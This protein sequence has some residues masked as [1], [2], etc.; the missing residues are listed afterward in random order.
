MANSITP[1]GTSRTILGLFTTDIDTSG[2]ITASSF[3]GIGT[4]IKK[5]NATNITS[6][7]LSTICGGTGNSSYA[8]NGITYYNNNKLVN[9]TNLQWIGNALMINNRDFLSDTSNYVKNTSNNLINTIYGANDV[10]QF[11]NTNNSNYVL[12]T[13]NILVNYINT[14]KT[15]NVSLPARTNRLG[16]VKIGD[17]IYVNKEGTISVMPEIIY[18][19]S[20]TMNNLDSSS[21]IPNTDYKIYK[22]KYN[23]LIGTS[24]DRQNQIANIL[25]TWFQF[26]SDNLTTTNG[27]NSIKNK[28]YDSN[29]NTNLELYGAVAIKP[30]PVSN[31]NKE[32]TPLN[33]TYLEVNGVTGTPTYCKFGA[34]FNLLN[35]LRANNIYKTDW[36]LTISFWFKVNSSNNEIRILDCNNAEF[37][38]TNRIFNIHY[39]DN[40]L[41]FFINVNTPYFTITNINQKIWYHIVWSIEKVEAMFNVRAY[42]DGVERGF[43]NEGNDF[44]FYV[45]FNNF[46]NNSISSLNNTNYTYNFNLSDF[47]IYN[48]ALSI[49]EINELYNANNYTQYIIDF[50]NEET[51]CDIIAYG[52]GGGGSIGSV[53]LSSNYGGGAGKLIYVNDAYIPPGSKTLKVGRGGIGYKNDLNFN[54]IS[55]IGNSTIFENLIADGGGTSSNYFNRNNIYFINQNIGGCGSG[56]YGAKT[57]FNITNDLY[58]LFGGTSNIYNFGH[59]GGRYGGGGIGSVGD[60]LN[61][62]TGLFE[63]SG[64]INSNI[65]VVND[66]NTMRYF[67]FNSNINFKTYFNLLNDDNIGEL[68][69]GNIY[70]GCGGAGNSN[71]DNVIVNG[72]QQLGYNSINSGCGGNFGENG[73]NGAFFLRF[74]TKIDQRILPKYIQETSNYVVVS[75]NNIIN[76]VSTSSNNIINYVKNITSVNGQSLWKISNNNL[77]YNIGNV[78]IG[79]EPTNYKLEVAVGQGSTDAIANRYFNVSGGVITSLII[80]SGGSGYS[81]PPT[82][83]FTGGGGSGGTGN[84]VVSN[85]AITSV[86]ITSGGS[87]YTS[88]PVVSFVG[89]NGATGTAVLTDGVITSVIITAGGSE[90]SN[91]PTISF[92]G[93]DGSGA[94][95]NVVVSNGVITSVNITSGGS[96]YSSPPTVSFVGGSGATGTV[97]LTGGAISSL[98]ITSG[99]S[100]YSNPPTISFTGGGGIGGAGNVVV[101]NGAITSVRITSGGI[102][103]TSP[104]AVSFVGG[105]GATGTAVLTGGVITSIVITAGGNGYSNPPTVS[106]AGGGGSGGTGNVVVSNGVITS[107]NI[108]SGGSG[109][110]SLPTMVFVGGSGATCTAFISNLLTSTVAINDVCTKFNSSIWIAGGGSVIASSDKRIKEDIEDINDDS[111][112]NMIL[113]IEPKTYKYIDKVIKGDCKVY[114]FIAQQIREVIADAVKI[115]TE[116]IPNIFSVAD[117]DYINNILTLPL[118]LPF[119][120]INIR[121]NTMIKCIDMNNN[122]IVVEIVKIININTFEIKRID[123]RY[124]KIFVYGTEVN[125]FHALNKEYINTL[126]VCAVQELHRKIVLQQN[127]INDLTEKINLLINYFDLSKITSLEEEINAMKSRMDTI[128]SCIDLP[129]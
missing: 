48:K 117:Y 37:L 20:P 96:G 39:V 53:N 115:Q 83:S 121:V 13:S 88:P 99:G 101:S 10:V 91:P 25:P 44:L 81:N 18:M 105:N 62:G 107:V 21:P 127:Q 109:Y 40:K 71:I 122:V 102:G 108:T 45:S 33:T 17:G 72:T 26:I 125:D 43:K 22:L 110:T 98:T 128:I 55:T 116:F 27:I 84:V 82:I 56:N 31:I 11:E 124:N 3:A 7:L 76:Y 80:T 79:I 51:I 93:G 1:G 100:G 19:N 65:A 34:E 74:L 54:Q 14:V 58:N 57:S 103:Y 52:G 30:I 59:V 64:L 94:T 75:S 36:A 87:G 114:G 24:F 129:I 92:A 90:Y 46:T 123:Y 9:N 5:L 47:K 28:G 63:L 118:S 86:R 111:A 61:G 2:D 32:Y 120:T 15:N 8:N 41:I 112:L 35:I 12:T 66:D 106:F 77:N 113:A 104:P 89:G 38:G 23:P 73:K 95:G 42:I 6:G 50:S 97:V 126:N 29:L 68:N 78:G 69:N 70:I 60:L 16:S 49:I 85:G 4:N 67:N 119:E